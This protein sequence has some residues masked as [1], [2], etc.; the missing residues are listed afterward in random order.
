VAKITI[1]VTTLFI[2]VYGWNIYVENRFNTVRLATS[3]DGQK[4][5]AIAELYYELIS[6]QL[7]AVLSFFLNGRIFPISDISYIQQIHMRCVFVDFD[8]V[9][10]NQIILLSFDFR[11]VI[12]NIIDF[13]EPEFYKNPY[14]LYQEL[15][16]EGEL[17]NIANKIWITGRFETVSYLIKDKRLGK[18]YLAYIRNRYG[19]ELA[20][21]DAFRV[22]DQSILMQNNP[23]RGSTPEPPKF[24][25]PTHSQSGITERSAPTG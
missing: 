10:K 7:Q 5:T 11:G 1:I 13:S 15:R 23:R 16:K 24:P 3:D 20:S 17:V 14:Q 8:I 25:T 4:D 18:G 21:G 9:G 12:V 22:F 2:E 6:F 19:D